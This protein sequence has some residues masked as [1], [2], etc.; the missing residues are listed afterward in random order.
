VAVG[1]LKDSDGKYL[2]GKRLDSQSWAGWWE[3]PGGK[4]ESNE[5]PSEALKREIYEE[6]GVSINKYR[7]WITRRVIEK[8]KITILYFFLITSWT[9]IVEGME[10]QKLQWVDF[11]TYNATKVLPP[12][13]VIHHALKNDLPEIYAITNFQE[14][15]SDYFFQALK[16]QVHKGL[17]LIQI[18]EKNLTVTE[19][20]ALI[21]RIKIILK[22]TNVRILINSSISLAYKYQLDGVHL[23]SKQLYELKYFPK[24]LLVGV[25][26]HSAKDLEVAE[27]K[28]VD[29]AVLGS[30]KETLTHPNFKPIGWEKFNKLVD[31]S[32]IPIY[33]IGGMTNNDIPSS[34]DFG[35]I[36]IASQRAIWTR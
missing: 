26:C 20:E 33:S 36:G 11:K 13:Q 3:F 27:E 30:V 9:G 2:L 5:N 16:R 10:G 24:D 22:H 18:R 8:N 31:N 23:N 17:R 28:N 32:N 29:F 34:F 1:I 19:L 25:S 12:N 6:L 4:L 35:A 21:T 15:S 14:I 7:Q